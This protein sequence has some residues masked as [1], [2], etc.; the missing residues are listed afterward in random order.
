[1]EKYIRK[2]LLNL[3]IR[4]TYQ[5]FRYLQYAL[6]LCLENDEYLRSICKFLYPDSCQKFST[7]VDNVWNIACRNCHFPSCWYHGNRRFLI[8]ITGYPLS[9]KPTNSEFLDILYNYLKF[10]PEG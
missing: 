1:M 8:D 2:L 6:L 3:G 10:F 9:D 7:T 5:G 4:S